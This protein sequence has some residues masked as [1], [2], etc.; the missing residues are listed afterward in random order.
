[1]G[2]FQYLWSCLCHWHFK[3]DK[4]DMEFINTI[5]FIKWTLL[6]K[7]WWYRQFHP[8]TLKP[9]IVLLVLIE[10]V[11][12]NSHS[13]N[14]SSIFEI[15]YMVWFIVHAEMIVIEFYLREGGGR[16]LKVPHSLHIWC[17]SCLL[18]EAKKFALFQGQFTHYLREGL[19]IFLR[20]MEERSMFIKLSSV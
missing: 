16:K 14:W 9:W 12:F 7:I 19:K 20:Y 5:R 1:M 11:C 8:K 13:T 18:L 4:I 2:I 10:V 3:V 6:N 15:R 17:I